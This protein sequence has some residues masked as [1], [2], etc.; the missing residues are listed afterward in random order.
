MDILDMSIPAVKLLVPHLHLDER[1]CFVE[2]FNKRTL[3]IRGIAFDGVQD[4]ESISFQGVIRG[5]H[6][7]TFP[8]EQAKLVTCVQGAIFDVA[9]DIR[10]DSPTFGQYVS[11]VLTC[12][13]RFQLFI[14]RGF[15]HGFCALSENATVS[16]KCDGYYDPQSEKGVRF[17]DPDIDI[18]WPEM[19][20]PYRV[21][22]KD[23]SLPFL[24]NI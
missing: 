5:L 4:N 16:Y 9:V 11:A 12:G 22:P 2:V 14:P 7:Q 15:A 24:K 6:Y 18:E 17:D 20:V 3:A 19:E 8:F 10:R 23:M 1:G 13:N 21:S